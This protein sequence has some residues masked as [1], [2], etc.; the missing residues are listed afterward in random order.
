[1]WKPISKCVGAILAAAAIAAPVQASAQAYPSKPI[2]IIV[3]LAPGGI[4]DIAARLVA[5]KLGERL[6][7]PVVV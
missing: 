4:T 3:P 6:G 1:M 7:Q 5:A 2:R